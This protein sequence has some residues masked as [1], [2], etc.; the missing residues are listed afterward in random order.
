MTSELYNSEVV[1]GIRTAQDSLQNK[2]LE[3]GTRL[4]GSQS[5]ARP[6]LAK[7][8]HQHDAGFRHLPLS[9]ENRAAV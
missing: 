6:F 9:A 3:R 4:A 2:T 8:F 1:P 7:V 5:S